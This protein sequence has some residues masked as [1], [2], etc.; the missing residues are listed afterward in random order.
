MEFHEGL[1]VSLFG[2]AVLSLFVWIA[3]T[4]REYTALQDKYNTKQIDHHA[5]MIKVSH[6]LP[7]TTIL[8]AKNTNGRESLPEIITH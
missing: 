7:L 3:V 5:R 1:N 2:C 8:H 4:Q 6:F